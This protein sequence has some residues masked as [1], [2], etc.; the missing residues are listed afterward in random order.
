MIRVPKNREPTH[1]GEMLEE[2]FLEPLDMSQSEL[3]RRIGVPFQRINLLVNRK[4][5]MTVD[6][7]LRLQRLFGMEAGFWLN[8]QLRWDLYYA[9]KMPSSKDIDK[10]QPLEVAN[11]GA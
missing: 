4:R 5:A 10:I 6:T 3:A 1:P 7:S 8:C 11:S 2:E 9:Q